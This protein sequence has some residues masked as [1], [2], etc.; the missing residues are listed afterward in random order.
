MWPAQPKLAS[1][2]KAESTR[3]RVFLIP[4]LAAESHQEN[5]HRYGGLA[6]ERLYDESDPMGLQGGSFSTY[7]YTNDDP[8]NQVDPSGQFVAPTLNPASAA[9]T[10]AWYAGYG[11]GTLIYDEYS[12]QI[13]D[14]LDDV[15][16]S[17]GEQSNVIPFPQRPASNSGSNNCP[18]DDGCARDQ[19]AL[20]SRRLLLENLLRAGTVSVQDYVLKAR[21]FNRDVAT[22]NAR[23]PKNPVR[24]FP[25]GPRGV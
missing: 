16:N 7:S 14:A 22:H 23:C 8:L 19:K 17:P 21:A 12:T 6:S 2:P 10:L 20:L 3:G 13:D 1:R 9:V 5:A 24:P 11:I 18:P 15:L 4:S 25:I